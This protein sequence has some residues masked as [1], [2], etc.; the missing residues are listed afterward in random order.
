MREEH[1]PRACENVVQRRMFGPKKVEAT[2]G[3]RKIH[4]EKLHILYS[5]PNIVII[6]RSG[7]VKWAG[8]KICIGENFVCNC[9][10]DA[11][12]NSEY[13]YVAS[14]EWMR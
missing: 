6:I 4:N 1:R 14:N 12:D 3:W 5:S 13:I 7:K 11:P 9:F 8:R 10:Q 2:G